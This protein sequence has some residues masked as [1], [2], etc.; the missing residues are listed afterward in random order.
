[1][2]GNAVGLLVAALILLV[3]ASLGSEEG[4]QA[5]GGDGETVDTDPGN[6]GPQGASEGSGEAGAA[7]K[8]REVDPD[9][10][11]P[12]R[13]DSGEGDTGD[14]PRPIV[15]PDPVGPGTEGPEDWSAVD[16]GSDE[17][18]VA[19]EEEIGVAADLVHREARDLAASLTGGGAPRL[20]ED[21]RDFT[22][23]FLAAWSG[24]SEQAER[25]RDRLRDRRSLSTAE[26]GLIERALGNRGRS[27]TEPAVGRVASPLALAMDMRLRE[28]SLE[29]AL[30]SRQW[31]RAAELASSLLLDALDAPWQTGREPLLRYTEHLRNAQEQ[32][33]WNPAGDWPYKEMTV[34]GG[35]SLVAMRK[36]FLKENP[37]LGLSICTGL[38]DRANG[39]RGRSIHAGQVFRIPTDPVHTLVDLSSRWVLYLHGDEVVGSWEAGIGK[40]ST[41]TRTGSYIVGDKIDD[42]MW[43][44]RG[45]PEL[46]GGH[47]ENELGTR[48]MGW[49]DHNG[50]TSLGYHGTLHPETV[51]GMVS[52]G[53]VRFA[54]DE[55]EK[56]F[57]ILPI[58]SEILV[59]E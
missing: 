18:A 27:D 24:A 25:V 54:N 11:D 7:G 40:P 28:R 46:P 3:I 22:L 16:W 59:R 2:R 52:E 39:I 20:G 9:G 8:P 6:N 12:G 58:G 36:R 5:G 47:A 26:L 23:A 53:C 44:R 4:T 33:R 57:E 55:V 56:L 32:H 1:M 14:D 34:Q 49:H 15:T 51:G 17:G 45:A 50:P 30:G 19:I 35:D 31:K 42:P 21:R 43:F 13:S 29:R 10:A 37:G 38:I 41:P 48:W